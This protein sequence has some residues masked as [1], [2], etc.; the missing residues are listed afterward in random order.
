MTEPNGLNQ[1]TLEKAREIEEGLENLKAQAYPSETSKVISKTEKIDIS[2]LTHLQSSN[3]LQEEKQRVFAAM[4]RL[5]DS[6][7]F[8]PDFTIRRMP[9]DVF[10]KRFHIEIIAS[11]HEGDKNLVL[12]TRCKTCRTMN[13]HKNL[14]EDD[15]CPF[16]RD[17]IAEFLEK[18]DI[19]ELKPQKGK[20]GG[21]K[22]RPLTKDQKLKGLAALLSDMTESEQVELLN[23]MVFEDGE[24][25]LKMMERGD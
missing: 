4:A 2:D 6:L 14:D 20:S 5:T 7:G 1:A 21:R 11:V 22:K 25:V 23:S 18:H 10:Q 9:L 16:C 24:K 3:R 15:Y 19:T 12:F 13:F 17:K 8:L